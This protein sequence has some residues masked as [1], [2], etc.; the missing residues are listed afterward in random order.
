MT[1]RDRALLEAYARSSEG[2]ARGEAA[3]VSA[4]SALG[5][6][7]WSAY[8]RLNALLEDG[9]AWAEFPGVCALLARRRARAVRSGRVA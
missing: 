4:F 6:S 2:T 5:F 1:D 8:Q 7:P 9:E 3:R